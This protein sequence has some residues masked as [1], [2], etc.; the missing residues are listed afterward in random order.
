MRRHPRYVPCA[1][2]IIL[3]VGCMSTASASTR[4]I[5][6]TREGTVI[7][8]AARASLAADLGVTYHRQMVSIPVSVLTVPDGVDM[9]DLATRLDAIRI[10]A[11]VRVNR[12][13]EHRAPSMKT[14]LGG[15]R[16]R[17]SGVGQSVPWGV[18]RI[19]A[20]Y[21]YAEGLTGAGVSV[22]VLDTGIDFDHPDLA[23]NIRGGYNAIVPGATPQDDAG[24]GT[25]VAGVIAAI[26]NDI[27]VV[28]VAPNVDLY[29]VKVLDSDGFGST[30]DVIA[31]IDWC[32]Q[33]GMDVINMSLGSSETTQ[34]E[35]DI[36]AA[37]HG[38]GII[39]VAAAGNANLGPVDFPGALEQVI[40]VSATDIADQLALFSSVGPEVD[41]A[42]PGEQVLT[43]DMALGTDFADGTSFASPHVAGVVALMMRYGQELCMEFR[44]LPWSARHPR[45]S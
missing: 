1:G 20:D 25:G 15:S 16:P 19:S 26:D 23:D 37:A 14:R 9:D 27:D 17:R 42:A 22:A 31:G 44:R 43:T 8:Q 35:A 40:A 41:I 10:E 30:S 7:S 32:I 36:V 45:W 39:M 6:T 5:V 29:A 21:T 18:S 13:P 28:G 3:L 24:H 2:F 34:A 33:N 11:D 38:A 12:I 4:V